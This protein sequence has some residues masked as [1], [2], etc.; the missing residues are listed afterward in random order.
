MNNGIVRV[1]S[2]RYGHEAGTGIGGGQD[3]NRYFGSSSLD[4]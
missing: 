1:S 3:D 2:A 4:E